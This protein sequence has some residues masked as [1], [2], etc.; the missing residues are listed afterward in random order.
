MREDMHAQDFVR[1]R[2]NN[3]LH[4]PSCLA[5]RSRTPHSSHGMFAD[6]HPASSGLRF[7]RRKPDTC[8]LWIGK[9]GP[10][11]PARVIMPFLPSQR[12]P[13]GEPRRV[14]GKVRVLQPAQDI[15]NGPHVPGGCL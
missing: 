1:V 3:E 13:H 6:F 7:L 10:R 8:H 12:V 2:V 9:H 11:N 14:D 15:A 4:K 5:H